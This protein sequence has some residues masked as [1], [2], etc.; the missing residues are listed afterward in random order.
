MSRVFAT[1]EQVRADV[2]RRVRPAVPT[3]PHVEFDALVDRIVAVEL[4]YDA[5]RRTPGAMPRV[6]SPL[7][8][9]ERPVV[10]YGSRD[11]IDPP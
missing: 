6:P 7:P 9:C 10:P 2:A 5:R 1:A 3:M 4:K 8:D 11:P